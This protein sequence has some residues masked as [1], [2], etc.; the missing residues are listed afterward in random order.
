MLINFN[1]ANIHKKIS[2][3]KYFLLNNVKSYINFSN[4]FF[5]ININSMNSKIVILDDSVILY[6][7]FISDDNWETVMAFP[8][9]GLTYLI[10]NDNIKFFAYIDYFYRNCLMTMDLPL[11]IVDEELGIDGEYS[12]IEELTELLN[13]IFPAL[14]GDVDLTPYLKKREAAELYQPIG[15]YQPVGN[16][17]DDVEYDSSGKTIDFYSQGTLVDSID[18]RPFIKDGMVDSVT[19]IE[20][21]GDTYLHIVFNTDAGKEPIDIPLGDIFDA[22]NYYTKDEVDGLLDDKLDASAYTPTD[23]SNYYNKQEVDALIPEV[24]S[25]DGYAT[26]TWVKNQG[27]IN[28]LKT[29]N[30]ISL[31]GEG[32]IQIGSGGTIDAYTKAEADAKFQPKGDYVTEATVIQYIT[33]LQEQITNIMQTVSGCCAETG[34]T[35]YRWITMTGAND[36][37]CSGTTKYNK[38]KKQQ[39]TDGINWTDVSPLE[40]RRGSTVLEVNSP[41]CGY[42]P[43][44]QYRWKAAPVSDYMCIGTDKY[45]KVY[46]EVS[47]DNGVTWQHV[48]PEQTK[49]GNLIESASTDCGYIEY[50]YRWYQAP[51]S[52]YMCSGTSKYYKEYYQ[53]STDGG[54][55]WANVS[56]TQTR[57]GSLIEAQ[58]TDCGYIAPQYRWKAAPASDYMC[59][60][61]SKYYKVYY[62]VSYDGGVTWQHVVP[63]QTKRGDLI[64]AQSTDCGYQPTTEYRWVTVSGEYICIGTRKYEKEKEQYR[65]DGGAWT[66]TNPLQTRTGSL[67]EA[68]STDCGYDPNDHESHYL[69]FK[70]LENGAQYSYSKDVYY[71]TNK[72]VTW[73]KLRA[74]TNTSSLSSG[75]K[76]MWKNNIIDTLDLPGYFGSNGKSFNLEGNIMSIVAGDNFKGATSNCKEIFD[77]MFKDMPVVSAGNLVMP[78]KSGCMSCMDMFS[79]C[80]ALTVAPVLS[81]TTLSSDCYFEMFKGCTSLTTAP[82]LPATTLTH[83]CYCYMFSGCTSLTQAPAL[84]ATALT[85]SCYCAMFKECSSLTTAPVLSAKTLEKDCYSNMFYHCSSLNYIKC[86]ATDISANGCTTSWVSGVAST[87]TFVKA[88]SMNNWTRNNNG[89]PSNWTVQNA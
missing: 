26:E 1:T 46:Y 7:H 65:I 30:N 15:D 60:G 2:K 53:V 62:E 68:E 13:R 56:P 54:Q 33:N 34:E 45:Y 55:T 61:T 17:F 72:G 19:L 44:P 76:I 40:T 28:Q 31:I 88:S 41:D 12:D 84:P 32:N 52:D 57:Q 8:R 87:G 35:Q 38:E 75:S 14:N 23:L 69:T 58:S 70:V 21:S 47:Y 5:I 66:D 11:Y 86:L 25:L 6:Q 85:D 78:N 81:S 74:G 49:R 64:E 18:A 77:G 80:T 29:I 22:D 42:V 71:S 48:V 73:T 63:E 36:Y 83:W 67:I 51:A 24:P 4:P 20:L 3:K 79:G 16:Y 10:K 50:Q 27:Y 59:S 82:A 89:I 39:S 9:G 43:E 37:I